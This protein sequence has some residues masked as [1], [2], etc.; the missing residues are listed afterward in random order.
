M[1]LSSPF[2]SNKFT[3]DSFELEK[4][5]NLKAKSTQNVLYSNNNNS[6]VGF[7]QDQDLSYDKNTN[8]NQNDQACFGG[9]NIKNNKSGEEP[10]AF[11]GFGNLNLN[12]SRSDVVKET[13]FNGSMLDDEFIAIPIKHSKPDFGVDDDFGFKGKSQ[14][15]VNDNPFESTTPDLAPAFGNLDFGSARDT[16]KGGLNSSF[17]DAPAFG[18]IGDSKKNVG[19]FGNN[20]NN[21]NNNSNNNSNHFNNFNNNIGDSF[22]DFGLENSNQQIQIPNDKNVLLL[23][24]KISSLGYETVP[25]SEH[26]LSSQSKKI[27]QDQEYQKIIMKAQEKLINNNQE[28]NSA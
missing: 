4:N 21:N 3:D 8:L 22:G 9:N 20:N 13:G 14:D 23:D 6:L 24:N 28:N 5:K 19:A 11:G 2:A 1:G 25:V 15:V 10:P 18:G 17:G 7:G 26:M 12:S 16:P 27:S